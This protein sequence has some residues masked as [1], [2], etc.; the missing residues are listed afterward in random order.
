MNI[1]KKILFISFFTFLITSCSQEYKECKKECAKISQHE[2]II[3]NIEKVDEISWL[4][5]VVTPVMGDIMI[6]KLETHFKT[7]ITLSNGDTTTFLCGGITSE[8]KVQKVPIYEPKKI[9]EN[10]NTYY[11]PLFME[12]EY[13]VIK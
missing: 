3:L 1:I 9:K 4:E 10:N 7:A 13:K 8:M 6:T 2:S 5:T 11:E 12:F